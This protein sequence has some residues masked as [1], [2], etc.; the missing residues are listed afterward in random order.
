MKEFPLRVR[1]T[2]AENNRLL[3]ATTRSGLSKSEYVRWAIENSNAQVLGTTI[4]G[5]VLSQPVQPKPKPK[6]KPPPVVVQQPP[7]ESVYFETE[8]GNVE[9]IEPQ[10][11]VLTA[12]GIPP[13]PGDDT[14]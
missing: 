12:M 9:A 4:A 14:V 2:E 11:D 10:P 8:D 1:L 13:P 7:E 5:V 3:T 6:P